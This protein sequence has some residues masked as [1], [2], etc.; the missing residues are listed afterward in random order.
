MS[1][2]IR[3]FQI[4][5]ALALFAGSLLGTSR[6]VA[7]QSS[8]AYPHNQILQDTALY[9]F[10]ALLEQKDSMVIP[11]LHLGDSHIQAGYYPGAVAEG[12]QARFGNA[13]MGWVFPF[14]LAGTNGPEGYRWHSPVRW[15]SERLVDKR[16]T[17]PLGPGAITIYTAAATPSLSFNNRTTQQIKEVSLFYD[18]G[19]VA[20]TLQSGGAT[21]TYTPM[22][23]ATSTAMQA[24]LLY[25]IGQPEFQVS[26]QRSGTAP[27]RFY[28]GIIRNGQPGILYSAVGINGAQYFQ[29]NEL[30]STLQLQM[31]TMQPRLVI[32]SLGTN[33]AYGSRPD[34][35]Q[36][37]AEIDKTV[38][39]LRQEDPN[40]T[41][42][43]TTPPACM[44]TV[45]TA[46]RRKVGKR[47]KTL[48]RSSLSPCP[49]ITLVTEEI[50]KYCKE[51]GLACWDFNAVN[52]ARAALFRS[53]WAPDHVHFNPAGYRQQ[54]QL[55]YE[56]LSAAYDRY[57][58]L[59]KSLP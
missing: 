43:L 32:I 55:L 16:K 48:Y 17:D 54:G 25:P 7:A 3:L 47:Y 41:I 36:F 20:D 34:A 57:I 6:K 5:A 56:A 13:G 23:Y 38:H 12:L 11:V 15:Q 26:W 10:F 39:W 49:G 18:T 33:E 24:T 14:N 37:T 44:R 9:S 51:Q 46:Y 8:S 50:R 59:K 4:S 28:G 29:Y 22:P 1:L 21:V 19:D 31:A 27:F 53:G 52:N 45:R 2:N 42:L 40:V 58:R 30:N 35:A